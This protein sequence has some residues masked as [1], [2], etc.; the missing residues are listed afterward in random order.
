MGGYE[1]IVRDVTGL[2]RQR[3]QG[4]YVLGN[5]NK[6]GE[7]AKPSNVDVVGIGPSLSR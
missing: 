3:I 1:T 2:N 5:S 7:F 6:F 4:A